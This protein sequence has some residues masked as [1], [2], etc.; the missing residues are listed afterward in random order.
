VVTIASGKSV[1][2]GAAP[3]AA[4]AQSEASAGKNVLLFDGKSMGG[5]K[6]S[7][8]S[9]P[10]EVKIEKGN[11]ILGV[12]NDMTGVTWDAAGAGKKVKLPK[13]DYEIR[14]EAMRVDG[15]DFF[16]GL[17]F[18]VGDAPC[19]LIVGGWGGGVIGLSSINGSDA[20]E[21]ETTGYMEFQSQ[22]W[23]RIRVRVTKS[24]VQAWIDDKQIVDVS[25]EQRQF[26]VRI[27]VE[28]SRPL[29]IAT[30]RTAAALRNLS[31]VLLNQPAEEPRPGNGAS[32]SDRPAPPAPEK[33]TVRSAKPSPQTS[34]CRRC[35]RCG[36]RR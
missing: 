19:S 12:G 4:P 23:Y 25:R 17:T 13:E 10:G 21:N 34:C 35:R 16:C 26:G 11:L 14:L 22:R 27:E 20:S 1:P 9:S 33:G 3:P 6:E 15:R 32:P 24:D 8:F 5:W 31:L 18:L 36:R 2:A 28:A 29:G 7:D 30:W